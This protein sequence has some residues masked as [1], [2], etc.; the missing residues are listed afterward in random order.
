MTLKGMA[1]RRIGE[2]PSTPTGG[3]TVSRKSAKVFPNSPGCMANDF[4]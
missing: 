4:K 1:K 2:D 3:E